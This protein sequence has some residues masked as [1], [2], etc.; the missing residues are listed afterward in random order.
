VSLARGGG[1]ASSSAEVEAAFGRFDADRSGAIERGELQRALARLGLPSSDDYVDDVF[2][3]YDTD[4]SGA[5]DLREFKGYVA[6]KERAMWQAFRGLDV[7]ASGAITSAELE[8][9]VARAGVVIS[10]GEARRMVALLDSNSD[11]VVTF[12]EFKQYLLLLPSAQLR[13]NAAWCWM[14][15]SCDRVVT[16]PRDPLKQLVIGGIAGA[17]SRTCTAPV[18]RVR[19]MLMSSSGGKSAGQ[20]L[21]GVLKEDGVAGL[22]RGNGAKVTKVIPSSA[23]QFFFY[24]QTKELFLRLREGKAAAQG[25]GKKGA[26]AEIS[27]AERLLAG[28]ISA[29]AATLTTYPLDTI[30]SQ[31]AV[32]GGAK[33]G[34]VEVG[35]QI[36]ERGGVGGLYRGL[37]ATV[38]SDVWGIGVGFF[39]YDTVNAAFKQTFGRAPRAHEKGMVGGTCACL[40]MSLAMPL[41]VVMTRMRVQGLPGYPVV[42]K[43]A[44]DCLRTVAREEGVRALWRGIVPA[45]LKVFPMIFTSYFVFETLSKRQG[46]GGLRRYIE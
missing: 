46:V 6:K 30:G 45:Y 35:K 5:I 3:Q 15:S 36:V 20:L 11:G 39:L 31:M 32:A 16:S 22:W 42:Y 4:G 21:R 23:I 17:A 34:L 33:G 27:A 26:H 8:G 7:D 1:G 28:G 25:G 43:S 14:G 37:S 2:S 44:L 38:A 10:P 29:I 19:V 12:S 18:E 9:A 40:S 13:E 24:N 41:E